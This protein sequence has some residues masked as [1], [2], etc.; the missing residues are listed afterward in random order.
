[1]HI[2]G[3]A[4]AVRTP[5]IGMPLAAAGQSAACFIA[6]QYSSAAFFSLRFHSRKEIFDDAFK[7]CYF[8]DLFEFFKFRKSEMSCL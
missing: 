7:K 1:M 4:V 8:N 2:Q 6:Q 3:T 5:T